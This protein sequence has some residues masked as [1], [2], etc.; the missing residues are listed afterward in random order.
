MLQV[1]GFTFIVGGNITLFIAYRK[2][3]VYWSYPIDKFSKKGKLITTGIYSKIR[4]PIYLSF[5]LI[6][7]GFVMVQLDG[8]LL[9]MYVIGAIGLYY[10]AIDEEALLID[11]FGIAYES[12]IKKTG[13]FFVKFSGTK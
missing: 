2:L 13:R 1:I 10:Q 5:N 6:S 8:I 4:H 9:V 12:Y 11:Y 7:L 3:G